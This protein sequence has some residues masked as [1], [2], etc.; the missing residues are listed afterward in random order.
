MTVVRLNLV[1][2][3][4]PNESC[5]CQHL[6]VKV[7]PSNMLTLDP[8]TG[9]LRNAW[10][11]KA[12]NKLSDKKWKC[13]Y[14]VIPH[15]FV[16]GC[17]VCC[18]AYNLETVVYHG[19]CY[20][21]AKE[22]FTGLWAWVLSQP[23]YVYR[24]WFLLQLSQFWPCQRTIDPGRPQSVLAGPISSHRQDWPPSL[25]QDPRTDKCRAGKLMRWFV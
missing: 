2:Q 14:G 19:L 13:F 18:M 9:R 8:L 6:C 24:H 15:V 21:T 20:Q 22:K 12:Q 1:L 23:S 4:T 10:D 3:N 11:D 5:P 16:T 25:K 17:S 7:S